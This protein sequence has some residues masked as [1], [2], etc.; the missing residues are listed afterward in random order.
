[1]HE[2]LLI[3]SFLID[4]F[5][6]TIGLR[7]FHEEIGIYRFSL[8]GNFIGP[9]GEDRSFPFSVIVLVLMR[10]AFDLGSRS[11]S[12]L[13]QITVLILSELSLKSTQQQLF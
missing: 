8:K 9:M 13:L 10:Q 6:W 7:V 12:V 1:M 4:T 3:Y 2:L 11:T 5:S